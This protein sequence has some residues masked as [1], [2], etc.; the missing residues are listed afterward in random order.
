M[1][2]GSLRA[3]DLEN[4]GR[5]LRREFGAALAPGLSTRALYL[6]SEVGELAKEIIKASEYGAREFEATE[7]FREELGDA[8]FDLA[9]LADD[10]GATLEEC[11]EL[12]L[13]KLRGRLVRQGHIGSGR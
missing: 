2:D 6:V 5:E 13:N 11:L 3:L 9:L 7:H 8:L 4:L 12:S 1:A 10:A